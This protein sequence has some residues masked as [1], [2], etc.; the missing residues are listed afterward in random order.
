[1]S[2]TLKKIN[3]KIRL[4]TSSSQVNGR[5]L[6]VSRLKT[7]PTRGHVS[8]DFKKHM[9]TR[10]EAL[11][12]SLDSHA[13]V[14]GNEL[15][16]SYEE[17]QTAFSEAQ[18][19]NDFAKS[20]AA[21]LAEESQRE[22]QEKMNQV[23]EL[24][25]SKAEAASSSGCCGW[26]Q[27]FR[28][29]VWDLMS[30]PDSSSAAKL[31]SI[32]ILLL[33]V[34]SSTTFCLETMDEFDDDMSKIIFLYGEYICI[35]AFTL[36]YVVKL[37]TAPD[38]WG[39]FKAP[40]N[41]IDLVAILPFYIEVLSQGVGGLGSTRILRV[42]RLV[43][44]FRV[45]KLGGR[46]S[47]MQVVVSAVWDSMDML[48]MLGFLLLLSMILFSTLIYYC[49][50]GV[51]DEP[52]PFRSIPS[53]FWWCIVTLMTVG[54]GDV[55]PNTTS[56]QLVAS[57]AML[58]S[59]IILALPISVIGANFTQQWV[60]FKD[61]VKM[62]E[63]ANVL[64]PHFKDLVRF[65]NEH[66]SVIEELMQEV[67]V[68]Q[69]KLENLVSKI[70]TKLTTLQR[71]SVAFPDLTCES[72]Q[73]ACAEIDAD[74]YKSRYLQEMLEERVKHIQ[75]VTSEEF[76]NLLQ[77]CATKHKKASKKEEEVKLMGMDVAEVNKDVKDVQKH[78]L[79]SLKEDELFLHDEP[80]SGR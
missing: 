32:G 51:V 7:G 72:D 80:A 16:D 21:A 66:N 9:A 31:I 62:K 40:M 27:R 35:A 63:Q 22:C 65:L 30:E 12:T 49:E 60:I 67:R 70:R 3:R 11:E 71:S 42:V 15:E 39:F 17:N 50:N 14:A 19:D 43:R 8:T 23:Q 48:G 59:I 78:F 34:F 64:E 55:V 74:F 4:L 33:I 25:S 5:R 41:L 57:L 61:T 79:A 29:S 58:A 1:M 2:V 69:G 13:E 77:V 28:G 26:L 73:G 38:A 18:P 47:K 44:V 52:D 20:V 37:I 6:I 46:F 36:E 76:N 45:L 56:G 54:Y 75:L 68:T 10:S 24:G 53:S